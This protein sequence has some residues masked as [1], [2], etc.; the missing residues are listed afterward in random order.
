MVPP[1][2]REQLELEVAGRK[3][4]EKAGWGRRKGVRERK[5]LM[6]LDLRI[7][8]IHQAI[9]MEVGWGG[10]PVAHTSQQ[11]VQPRAEALVSL[12]KALPVSPLDL[13]SPRLMTHEINY[14]G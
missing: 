10:V 8:Q 7:R 6:V 12:K 2:P 3:R 1:P 11:Q 4:K 5:P 14:L 9:E 13:A